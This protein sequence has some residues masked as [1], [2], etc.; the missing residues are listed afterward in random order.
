MTQIK[1]TRNAGGRK[2]G[3]TAEVTAGVASHLIESGYAEAVESKAKATRSKGKA[4]SENSDSE[5]GGGDSPAEN[6]VTAG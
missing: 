1:M 2:A 6:P 5:G 3:D 4:S